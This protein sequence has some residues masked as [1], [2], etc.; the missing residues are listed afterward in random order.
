MRSWDSRK[1]RAFLTISKSA[2]RKNCRIAR[3]SIGTK[4]LCAV[5]KAN[6]YGHDAGLVSTTIQEEVDFFAVATV[7][8]AMDLKNRGIH[9]PVMVLGP[10][11]EDE[12]ESVCREEIRIPLWEIAE[13]GRIEDAAKK[14]GKHAIVHIALDTGMGRIGCRTED[15]VK[16]LAAVLKE[17]PS[18]YVEGMFSH[19]A[20]ADTGKREDIEGQL[21]RFRE[22]MASYKEVSPLP[23]LLHIANSAGIL[24]YGGCE[25]SM[26]RLGISLYG[27]RPSDELKNPAEKLE[28]VLSMYSRLIY[29]KTVPAGF[30]VGY[31]STYHTEKESIIGTVSVGYGDGYPR[32]LSNKGEVLIRG[33]RVPIVGRVCMDQLMVD[34]SSVPE[35]E[36]GDLVTLIGRDGDECIT[37]EELSKLSG[38][39][40]YE[41]LC[42]LTDRLPRIPCNPPEVKA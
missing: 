13:A 14:T 5:V 3:E 36:E 12:L 17:M 28:P 19:F 24:D 18:V 23:A 29:R 20:N 6:A 10:V 41:L 42:C 31:G 2:L 33:R 30:A 4:K 37:L 26:S 40:H 7:P 32:L 39:F 38:R 1:D 16:G 27:I 21:K 25:Y 11:F 9:K 8:E 34:L 35:A 15:E 22:L